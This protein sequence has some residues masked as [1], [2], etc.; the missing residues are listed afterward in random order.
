MKSQTARSG[1]YGGYG[2]TAM[3]LSFCQKMCRIEEN[4]GLRTVVTQQS[5]IF[6]PHLRSFSSHIFSQA[7]QNIAVKSEISLMQGSTNASK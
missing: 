7:A 4:V 6:A 2:M 5:V 1:E 3:F